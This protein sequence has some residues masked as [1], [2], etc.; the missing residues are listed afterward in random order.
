MTEALWLVPVKSVQTPDKRPREDRKVP[1]AILS[2]VTALPSWPLALLNSQ[3]LFLTQLRAL[4]ALPGCESHC[5]PHDS[6][7]HV[8]MD[9]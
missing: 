5:P 1:T 3:G 6:H 7:L 9:L 4:P 8:P 2:Q